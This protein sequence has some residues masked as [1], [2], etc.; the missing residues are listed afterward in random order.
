MVFSNLEKYTCGIKIKLPILSKE[1]SKNINQVEETK[2][3]D[4]TE[5][6]PPKEEKKE[7]KKIKNHISSK[8]SLVLTKILLLEVT[9]IRCNFLV[10]QQVLIG[11]YRLEL[12]RLILSLTNQ[13]A[14]RKVLI[15]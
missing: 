15:T 6:L 12:K 2:S 1:I 14:K 7:T 13:K 9:K 3:N 4:T 8:F 5:E 11:L 10:Y